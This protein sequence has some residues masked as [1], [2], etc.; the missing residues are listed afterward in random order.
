MLSLDFLLFSF[1]CLK[2]FFC[3]LNRNILLCITMSL[4]QLTKVDAYFLVQ[5]HEDNKYQVR[6]RG[7]IQTQDEV[8]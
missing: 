2:T 7:L 3:E 4:R 5:Y 8:K 1:S 6:R